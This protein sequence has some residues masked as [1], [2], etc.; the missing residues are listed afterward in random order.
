MSRYNFN[1]RVIEKR[2]PVVVLLLSLITC[3]IYLIFWYSK[4]YDELA[5]ITG[6]T[7][8]GNEFI[9]DL[10]LVIVT[11]GVWGIYVDYQIGLQLE[12]M[13]RERG[14]PTSDIKTIAIVLDIAQ[15]IAGFTGIITNVIL[16]D[17]F[18]KIIEFPGNNQGGEQDFRPPATP[19]SPRDPQTPEEQKFGGFDNFSKGPGA[20]D[21]E[22]PRNPY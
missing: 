21:D 4:T 13:Q 1:S 5:D 18:N 19:D 10:L 11:C 8:T 14:M 22:P 15:Y 17:Y 6:K 12:D 9:T 2:E 16:T 7:P 20:S 3:G